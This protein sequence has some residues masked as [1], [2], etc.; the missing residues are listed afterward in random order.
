M[1]ALL[2]TFKTQ[3]SV[4]LCVYHN[5]RLKMINQR[6]RSL[7]VALPHFHYCQPDPAGL[8]RRAVS[9]SRTALCGVG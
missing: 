9:I 8:T 3:F 1:S 5:L 7:M 4:T 2:I 6:R